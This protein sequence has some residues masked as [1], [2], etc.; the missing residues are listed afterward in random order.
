MAFGQYG[1]Y[2]MSGYQPQ[3]QQFQPQQ[4][5]PQQMPMQ[6]QLS[7]LRSQQMPR[8]QESGMIWVLG[9]EGA[10]AYIVAPGTTLPLWDSQA[11][12]IYIKSVD[13]NGVPQMQTINYEIE[14]EAPAVPP[15]GATVPVSAA[16]VPADYV[17]KAD[18]K[19]VMDE[20]EDL[21]KCIESL[22]KE[23]PKSTPRKTEKEARVNE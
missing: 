17:T 22:P 18:L 6:D 11:R 9:V 20:I 13:A 2:P 19:G 21:W 7:Q 3:Y 16:A 8:Q 1:A 23:A 12:K 14:G 5:Y 4:F 10:K 15:V